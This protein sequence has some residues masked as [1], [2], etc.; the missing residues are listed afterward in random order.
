MSIHNNI[1]HRKAFT[2]IEL[3]FVIIII[4]ILASIA[5][6]KLSATRM[7]AKLSVKAQN[8]MIAASEIVSYAVSHGGVEP[9][10][11]LMSNSIKSM[12][13][14]NE[15]VTPANYILNVK[16]EEINDCIILQIRNPGSNTETLVLSYGA[17]TSKNCDQLRS[18]ID[19]EAYPIVLRGQTVI[20]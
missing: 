3:I 8:I 10:L 2:A 15:A 5:I 7:D 6:P 4:S 1:L 16:V 11:S 17:T 20:Y 12:L 9:T 18:L 14:R 19:N 13:E